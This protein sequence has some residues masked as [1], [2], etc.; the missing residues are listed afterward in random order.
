MSIASTP[1][2]PE[3]LGGSTS[4]NDLARFTG[5]SRQPAIRRRPDVESG[6]ALERIGH[7]IEYLIDSGRPHCEQDANAA[8]EEAVAILKRASLEVFAQCPVVRPLRVRMLAWFHL[9][10][11][12]T[13][14]RMQ[15]KRGQHHR[16]AAQK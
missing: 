9:A 8:R 4:P 11:G 5:I 16:A 10:G 2:L 12:L 13:P 7:A 3:L 15:A 14:N 6:R 1:T